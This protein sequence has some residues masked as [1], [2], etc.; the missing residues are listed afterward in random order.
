MSASVAFSSVIKM[1][2]KCIGDYR[3]KF[4]S[5]NESFKNCGVDVKYLRVTF[6]RE[7]KCWAHVWDKLIGMQIVISEIHF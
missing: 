3:V 7:E 4:S 5:L 1:F 2:L 6:K